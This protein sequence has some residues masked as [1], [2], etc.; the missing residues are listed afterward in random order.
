MSWEKLPAV[1]QEDLNI[2]CLN[3]STAALVAPMDM[4]VMV[5]FGSAELHRSCRSARDVAEGWDGVMVLSRDSF[6]GD[7]LVPGWRCQTCGA[8]YGTSGL[9]PQNHSCG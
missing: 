8:T 1:K 2:G 7:R 3:C 4:F 9:P 5:G 6:S